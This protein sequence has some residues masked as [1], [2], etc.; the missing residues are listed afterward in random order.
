[1]TRPALKHQ[2]EHQTSEE[3][4]G[5]PDGSSGRHLHPLVWDSQQHLKNEYKFH[6]GENTAVLFLVFQMVSAIQ[7]GS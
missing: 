2:T 5:R 1:M 3:E 4:A 6:S 7:Q